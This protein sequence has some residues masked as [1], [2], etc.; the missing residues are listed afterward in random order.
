VSDPLSPGAM[1]KLLAIAAGDDPGPAS[2]S[3]DFA[4][5]YEIVRELGRG[6]MGVVYEATD[7]HLGRRCAV[8][9]I[10]AVF[11]G[12]D[13]SRLRLAREALAA[14]RLR[15][16]HIAAIYD[17]T[18]DY[19]SMQLVAGCPIGAIHK[20][21]RRLLVQLIR[22]A[23]HAVQ[24]AHE[25]GVVHRDLK[26]SNLL[27]EGAHVFVVDFGLAKETAAEASRTVSGAVVGTPAFMSPEQAQGRSSAVDAR[28]D[29][30]ALGATLYACLTG[31]PPFHGSDIVGLLRR[32]AEEPP[33][34]PGIERD[35]DLVVLKCLEK[36]PGQR[37]PTAAA[38]ADD[39][40]RW[41]RNE[42]VLARRPSLGYRFSKLLQRR[43][44][45]LRASLFTALGAA[46][47]TALI[48][49]PIA[50]RESVERAAASEAVEL[51]QRSDV[52]LQDAAVFLRLGDY[53][54]AHHAL[55]D[56]IARAREFLGRHKIP[57]VRY[58]LSRL[59]RARGQP[60]LALVELDR[61]IA[62]DPGLREARFE[63][64]LMSAARRDLTEPERQAA[65]ADLTSALG[66]GA[67]LTA[68]DL[69]HGRGE[70]FRLQS[71]LD[72][73]TECLREV[74]AY[75]V[76]H[77]GARNSLARIALL[78]GEK[79][80]ARYYSVSA[81]DLQQGFGPIYLARE[82]RLLPTTILGLDAALVDFASQ[83]ADGPD[84][85]LAFAHRGLVHLRRALR[86]GAEGRH[87]DART[88]IESAIEDH[89]ATLV[90][91]SDVAG[92]FNNRAVCLSQAERIYA[93]SGDSAAAAD[94]H[95]RASSD[96][97]RALDLDPRL[98]EAH[99]NLGVFSLRTVELLRKLGH[100]S[101][102][103]RHQDLARNSLQRAKDLAPLDW[104]HLRAC[105]AKLAQ[106]PASSRET[107][108]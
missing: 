44:V 81:V 76:M 103:S 104:P 38:L 53:P 106:S 12:G 49:A 8:K 37:Y 48:L 93:A 33:K 7:R 25:Q 19:I 20:S 15:H 14:A 105:E 54:S 92:A 95:A 59:L 64:G 43:K 65:I 35:L 18:P 4:S 5:R 107:T 67:A 102:A 42:P 2:P 62:A 69:L 97:T 89:D 83:L 34:A 10:H 73:A 84:N 50:W 61:A 100:A 46:V 9:M 58:L 6:G 66:A 22:D 1:R 79:D 91:H 29:V 27:V 80:L 85:A 87:E 70:L 63:R 82:R 56:G 57:R 26:P 52:T 94:A 96:F 71:Q 86:L 30:Y 40:D 78:R 3:P 45:L 98:P 41:L 60:D 68:V 32:I 47:V 99:F 88:S 13:E 77:V 36:D 23:A 55:E 74:L 11:G 31:A 101:A 28:T 90:I 108:R 39:L 16:P 17:A 24:H 72:Q 75:D 51:S 21:E